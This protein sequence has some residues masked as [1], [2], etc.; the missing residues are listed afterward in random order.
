MKLRARQIALYHFILA[1][2]VDHDYASALAH[3]PVLQ[4]KFAPTVRIRSEVSTKAVANP[5]GRLTKA[6]GLT[7]NKRCL[8]ETRLSIP[9]PRTWVVGVS[10]QQSM[11]IP[12]GRASTD[13]DHHICVDDFPSNAGEVGQRKFLVVDVEHFAVRQKAAIAEAGRLT[14]DAA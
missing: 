1:V 9:G 5:Q 11:L 8:G 4:P 2:F 7:R 3:K 6:Y 10:K 13:N 14:K 12:M